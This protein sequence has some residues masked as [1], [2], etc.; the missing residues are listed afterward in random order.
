MGFASGHVFA[1]G[2]AVSSTAAAGGIDRL[3]AIP[4]LLYQGQFHKLA[5]KAIGCA[6]L[7]FEGPIVPEIEPAMIRSAVWRRWKPES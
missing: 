3:S 4:D 1:H 2:N 6:R 5:P 7:L